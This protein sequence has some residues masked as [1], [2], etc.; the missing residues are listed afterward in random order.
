MSTT[1]R[2]PESWHLFLAPAKRAPFR[3]ARTF[4]LLLIA[5][6]TLI[7]CTGTGTTA[8]PMVATQE[9][10]PPTD[11]APVPGV[12]LNATPVS[13]SS[14]GFA[15][16]SWSSTDATSCTASGGWSGNRGASGSEAT[17][18][19]SATTNYS[20]TCVGAGGSDS[21]TVT[22]TVAGSPTPPP[23]APT[24][25]FSANPASVAF[26]GS[27]ALSWSATNATS[28]AASGGWSGS[29][30]VSGTNVSTGALTTTRTYSLTCTGT[31][32]SNT[33]S[34]TVTVA[35][36]PA[37]TLSLSANPV[38][39]ASG[40]ASNLSW[41]A[42]NASSCT[43]SGAWSGGKPT[44]GTSVST[45]ALTASS[46]FTLACTGSGGTVTRDVT[47]SVTAPPAP[48]LSLSANPV[49]V[50]S[51]GAATLSWSAANATS[52]TASGGWSGTRAITG[53]ESTGALTSVKTYTLVC[54]GTGGNVSKSVTVSI[55]TEGSG[56]GLD[57]PGSDATTGTIRF[58]FTSPLSIYPATYIWKVM[59]RQQDGYYT[60][61][62]WGNN[63]NF[64]WDQGAPNTTYGAHPYPD[65]QPLGSTH[66]WEIAANGGD[67]VN[68]A[69]GNNTKV[70]YNTWYTQA[71]RVWADGSGKH[72]EFY[73]AL[74]DT[75]K[76]IRVTESPS[77]AET[78]PP[79]PVLVW[80]DAP[81][82]PSKEIMNGVI[83]G[84]Q[85]YSATLSVADMLTESTSA[86]STT[87]GAANVWYLNLN[88]IPTDITDKSG[89]GHHPAWVG[90]ERPGLW[91]AP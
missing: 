13:I 31:G 40:G 29:K 77:Y 79:S 67:Y 37:P 38:S 47:V 34:V 43:A 55:V 24:L 87:T 78:Q 11:P 2:R 63:G 89:K 36:A 52:C 85:I 68:D 50:T 91:V 65:T 32:G 84:I 64:W 80:G 44:S 30:A 66:K 17:P 86:L 18:A 70:V 46:T 14:G 54:S 48:T 83:R 20:I 27:S 72:H 88:P 61:F 19:L 51:G 39:V 25:T 6:A 75:S 82:N 74:P 56:F 49:S 41:S 69:N 9:P 45:G 16:L 62:F 58:E 35:A 90:A 4:G 42:T 21:A 33:K 26:N 1:D 7:A 10:A 12:T 76:V 15:T 22:V 73:W 53:N 28:C 59:P 60:T 5:M 23:A 81:W 71:L 3:V 57:F 8:P